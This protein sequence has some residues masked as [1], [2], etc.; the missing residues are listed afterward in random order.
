MKHDRKALPELYRF[1]ISI[2]AFRVG[3]CSGLILDEFSYA[4]DDYIDQLTISSV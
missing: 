4:E 1:T 2:A 3:Y